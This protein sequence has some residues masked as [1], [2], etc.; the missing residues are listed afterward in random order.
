MPSDLV[1]LRFPGGNVHHELGSNAPGIGKVLIKDGR[2]WLVAGVSESEDGSVSIH[3]EEHAS[4]DV[5]GH[6][7]EL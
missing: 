6:L 1:T 2:S 4:A 3:L 5:I 7:S